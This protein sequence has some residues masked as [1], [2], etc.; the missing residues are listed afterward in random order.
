M[1]VPKTLPGPFT[2]QDYLSWNDNE[3]RREVFDGVVRGGRYELIRGTAYDR[4]G[5]A[6]PPPEG[7]HGVDGVIGSCSHYP[8]GC[9]P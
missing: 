4:E 3:G 5:G 1:S 9:A 6:A 8:S 2:V 7:G